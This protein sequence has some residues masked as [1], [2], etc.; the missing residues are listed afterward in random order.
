MY[1]PGDGP[2]HVEPRSLNHV[3]DDVD[4]LQQASHGQWM[5]L[6]RVDVTLS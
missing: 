4:A 5:W 1:P 3:C 6:I 2:N